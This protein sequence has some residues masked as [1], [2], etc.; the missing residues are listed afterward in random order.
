MKIY[1]KC[2][3]G[4]IGEY[5]KSRLII[6]RERERERFCCE[7]RKMSGKRFL[8]TKYEVKSLISMRNIVAVANDIYRSS[9]IAE[10][11]KIHG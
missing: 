1:N 8:T 7:K 2:K 3:N 10:C 6:K 9:H 11:I 5:K 4:E